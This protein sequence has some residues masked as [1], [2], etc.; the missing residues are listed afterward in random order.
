MFAFNQCLPNRI[1]FDHSL[2]LAPDQF[3]DQFAVVGEAAILD[4]T[5]DPGIVLIG[6]GDGLANSAMER[7]A[8][9]FGLYEVIVLST[10]IV[11]QA[12]ARLVLGCEMVERSLLAKPTYG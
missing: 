1:A 11:L 10:S 9:N 4:L 2:L 8:S 6:H 12:G 5:G 7:L 3:S